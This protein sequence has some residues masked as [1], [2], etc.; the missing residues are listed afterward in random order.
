M[1]K[2]PKYRIQKAL[3][4]NSEMLLDSEDPQVKVWPNYNITNGALLAYVRILRGSYYFLIP[5]RVFIDWN[6]IGSIMEMFEHFHHECYRV[7]ELYIIDIENWD[8]AV[9]SKGRR[10]PHFYVDKN[11][12]SE[13][14]RL[15]KIK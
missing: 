12:E 13:E 4:T 6:K 1:R 11:Q 3:K 15:I 2:I 9:E 10:Y 8:L 14:E 5:C 7:H